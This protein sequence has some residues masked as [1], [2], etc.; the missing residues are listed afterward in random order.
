MAYK[1]KSRKVGNTTITETYRSDGS[2][3][4]TYT[5]RGGSGAYRQ[6]ESYSISNNDQ[7]RSRSTTIHGWLTKTSKKIDGKS[8][9]RKSKDDY[10]WIKSLTK[11]LNSSSKKKNKKVVYDGPAPTWSEMWQDLKSIFKTE[12]KEKVETPDFFA[13]LSKIFKSN[14]KKKVQKEV[15]DFKGNIINPPK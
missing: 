3:R 2:K 10:A 11:A 4:T 15:R 8:R 6:T 13:E 12:P 5:R 9:R 1:R 14:T 7:R